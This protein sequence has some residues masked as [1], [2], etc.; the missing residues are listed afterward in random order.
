MQRMAEESTFVPVY[1]AHSFMPTHIAGQ[2]R[3]QVLGDVLFE[4]IYIALL[5]GQTLMTVGGYIVRAVV[6]ACKTRARAI[7]RPDGSFEQVEPNQII[8][9]RLEDAQPQPL[10]QRPPTDDLI[11]AASSIY[12]AIQ[13]TPSPASNIGVKSFLPELEAQAMVDNSAHTV[14]DNSELPHQEQIQLFEGTMLQQQFEQDTAAQVWTSIG[15]GKRPFP[16]INNDHATASTN[17][18]HTTVRIIPTLQEEVQYLNI[19][20]QKYTS[21][22]NN[23]EQSTR[24]QIPISTPVQHSPTKLSTVEE[25]QGPIDP[26]QGPTDPYLFA[27]GHEDLQH[28]IHGWVIEVLQIGMWPAPQIIA[29]NITGVIGVVQV[30]VTRVQ[31]N[32]IGNKV[33][34]DANDEI[35]R[36]VK[37]QTTI[38]QHNNMYQCI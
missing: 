32:Q 12:I 21:T 1:I 28:K 9:A 23:G 10:Q 31:K 30:E 22:N 11:A 36:A 35:L 34:D 17:N 38:G 6:L 16:P 8:F 13:N 25:S 33:L 24:I 26:L 5:A 2:G 29:S 19:L 27:L 3:G 37:R 20:I 7:R 15:M 18:D 4:L 14:V